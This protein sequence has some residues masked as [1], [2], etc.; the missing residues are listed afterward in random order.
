MTNAPYAYDGYIFW[1][2]DV[3]RFRFQC[4]LCLFRTRLLSSWG[5]AY[6]ASARHRQQCHASPHPIPPPGDQM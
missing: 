1:L 5:R 3:G 2:L 6:A 4:R